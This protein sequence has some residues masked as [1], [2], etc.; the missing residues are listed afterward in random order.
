MTAH[1]V[2]VEHAHDADLAAHAHVG[3]HESG[4]L[5]TVPL[6][7]LAVLST[8]AGFLNW[9]AWPFHSE[10][11]SEWFEPTTGQPELEHATFAYGKAILSVC[12][13]AGAI[14]FVSYLMANSFAFLRGLTERSK[15][16]RAGYMFLVNKYYLDYLYE[17]IIVAG[18]SGPIARGAYWFNQNVIDAIVNRTGDDD[19]RGR[20]LRLQA[21][22]TR[23]WSTAASTAPARRPRM[24]EACCGCCSQ[25]RSSSTARF[26]SALPP[27]GR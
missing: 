18:I 15:V 22:S 11:F 1:E 19:T 23:A 24:R 16:A 26:C 25:E 8:V 27:S 20:Q 9:A 21:A 4:P 7:I 13:V 2:E 3:P 10:K 12:L 14:G 5:L 6:I 17:N